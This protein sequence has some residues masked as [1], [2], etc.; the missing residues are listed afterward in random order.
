MNPYYQ[1]DQVTLYCA[2]CAVV[3]PNLLEHDL[4]LTDPPYG[5]GESNEKNL[6]RDRIRGPRRLSCLRD[7][8]H[9]DWDQRPIEQWLIDQAI[10]KCKRAIVFGGNYYVLGP[11][12]CWLIWDK[13]NSGDFSPVELA[14]TNLD[15]SH[16]LV[17]HM[18]NGMLRKN[19]ESRFHPT[20][21]PLGVMSWAIGT[22]GNVFDVLDPFA[23]SGTTL[24]AAKLKGLKAT[25]IEREERYCEL[26][27]E[28][29]NQAV[30]PIGGLG[31]DAQELCFEFFEENG[32]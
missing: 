31:F 32:R 16:R 30:L 25:G 8:G 28:R 21:K 23:G 18:W 27:C 12:K 22:A 17:R 29:L 9:F 2:D 15:H 14:W 5:I 26:I 3:L 6:S 13:E 1:D 24:L 4:L 11:A 10:A 20:Q 7:Y 19:G